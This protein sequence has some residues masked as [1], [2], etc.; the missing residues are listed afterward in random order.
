[1]ATINRQFKESSNFDNQETK[2]KLI[3]D[4]L[5]TKK[6]IKDVVQSTRTY[7]TRFK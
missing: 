3:T 5:Q 6:Q 4:E 1:L 7:S 2:F